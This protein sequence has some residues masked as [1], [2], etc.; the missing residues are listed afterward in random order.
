MPAIEVTQ[1]K[2]NITREIAVN[3]ASADF[4]DTAPFFIRA[5]TGGVITYIP[6]GNQDNEPITKTIESSAYFIDPVLC[7]KILKQVITSPAT[8]Y[9]SGIHVGYGI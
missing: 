1:S 6:V 8:T 3:V 4:S 9:A 2:S 5:T 7:R